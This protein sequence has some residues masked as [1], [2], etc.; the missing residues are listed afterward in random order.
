VHEHRFGEA[1]RL[2]GQALDAGTQRQVFALDLLRLELPH[3]VVGNGEVAFVDTG[4]IGVKVDNAKGL[5]Q[6][7]Q[8]LKNR[9]GSGP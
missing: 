6:G 3:R 7:V 2:A 4:S 5:E 1:N 8:L 9:I